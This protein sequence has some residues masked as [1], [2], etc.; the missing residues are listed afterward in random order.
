MA[1]AWDRPLSPRTTVI[2]SIIAAAVFA[3][4]ITSAVRPARGD[5]SA[6][7]PQELRQTETAAPTAQTDDDESARSVF[8]Q[9]F[10]TRGE[11]RSLVF[12]LCLIAVLAFI[13]RAIMRAR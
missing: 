13:A 5:P 2:L 12:D 11:D 1:T 8:Y 3:V 4:V 7:I 9:V 6:A 10:V